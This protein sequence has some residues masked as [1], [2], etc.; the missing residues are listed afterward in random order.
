M[1]RGSEITAAGRGGGSYSYIL[2]QFEA[3][4]TEF[5]RTNQGVLNDH[6]H[7]KEMNALN[8]KTGSLVQSQMDINIV[9]YRAMT[10]SSTHCF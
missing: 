5:C 6:S 9:G 1:T 2:C 8:K 10:S 3:V 4:A 7:F